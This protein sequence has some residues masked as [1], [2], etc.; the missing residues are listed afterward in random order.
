MS[1]ASPI[2]F[3]TNARGQQLCNAKSDTCGGLA[4]RGISKCRSHGGASLKGEASG[5][6]KNGLRSKYI[7]AIPQRIKSDLENLRKRDDLLRLNDEIA[8][9][10]SR[11]LDILKRVDT[12]EAGQV[13]AELRKA[14]RAFV[15]AKMMGEAGKGEMLA[16][17][18][19]MEALIERGASDYFAWGEACKLIEQRR[20]LV[21]SER[22]REL[23]QQEI[24][25]G[26]EAA[27]L[28]NAL[29]SIVNEHVTDRDTK[30]RIQAAVYDLT[31]RK[32][33]A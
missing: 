12:G 33:I 32:R 15:E 19:Q 21:E 16:A 14:H 7:T 9:I 4:M 30:Q 20:R 28:F 24:L 17:M 10:D 18:R 1:D 23:E 26:K 5:T 13:W 22:K 27:M 2:T 29:L 8:L 31:S 3:R 6:F 25:T 11:L